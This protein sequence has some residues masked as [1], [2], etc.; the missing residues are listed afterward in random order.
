V[1]SSSQA[2]GTQSLER[3]PLT[4]V[5]SL[6]QGGWFYPRGWDKTVYG[7]GAVAGGVPGGGPIALGLIQGAMGT[8][9]EDRY[10]FIWYNAGFNSVLTSAITT[11]NVWYY[12]HWIVNG[13][14][15]AT[16]TFY[17]ATEQPGSLAVYNATTNFSAA[18][19]SYSLLGG[20]AG[21]TQ[22]SYSA[23]RGWKTWI[24]VTH[25]PDQVVQEWSSRTFAPVNAA[26]LHSDIRLVNGTAPGTATTGSNWAETG[27]WQSGP[28]DPVPPNFGPPPGVWSG[29]TR[30]VLTGRLPHL[31]MSEHLDRERRLRS[32]N[33]AARVV[34]ESQQSALHKRARAFAF[35]SA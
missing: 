3:S 35:L 2:A 33:D 6:I 20:D 27:T 25:T 22:M 28:S 11:L 19:L 15:N 5:S 32:G 4:I 31:R 13:T 9:G 34:R 1:S 29:G 26:G 16:I 10:D 7:I 14:S 8:G 21:G 18:Q 17:L 30:D 12:A 24:D 23:Y